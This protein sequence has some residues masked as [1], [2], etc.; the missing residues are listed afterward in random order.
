[1]RAPIRASSDARRPP[2]TAVP[3]PPRRALPQATGD[4]GSSSASASAVCS[5]L[6]CSDSPARRGRPLSSA[7]SV[8]SSAAERTNAERRH[9]AAQPST[10]RPVNTCAVTRACP[11]RRPRRAAR[12]Q[13]CCCW[14]WCSWEPPRWRGPSSCTRVSELRE[15]CG[16]VRSDAVGGD[17]AERAYPFLARVASARQGASLPT[18]CQT[19]AAPCA[20]KISIYRYHIGSL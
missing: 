8:A 13:P 6:R 17:R 14:R 12:W 15:K 3:P 4:T 1:M 18:S 19:A 5:A 11:S 10:A 9:I 7:Q 2:C 16:A 20:E